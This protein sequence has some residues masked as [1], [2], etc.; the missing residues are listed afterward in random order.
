MA[1]P[2]PPARTGLAL[3]LLLVL[4]A[5][6]GLAFSLAKL[7]QIGGIPPLGYAIWQSGGAGLVLLVI[8]RVRGVRLPLSGRHIRYYLIAALTG[9]AIPIVNMLVVVKQIPVGVIAV[10][11]TLS[12][13]LTYGLAMLVGGERFVARRFAGMLLGFAGALLILIPSSSLPSP[14]MAP[15]V[16][17]ALITPLFFAGSN[18]YIAMARPEG[19]DS[20]ALAA[21]MQLAVVVFV[22]PLAAATGTAY[23]PAPDFT[24]ADWA[25]LA[26]IATACFTALAMFEIIRLAGV[27]FMSQVAYIVTLSGI[28][29]G[30]VFFDEQHSPWIWASLVVILAGVALV[31]KPA[32]PLAPVNRPGE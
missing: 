27:V 13:L 12:P 29:W 31:T 2:L 28:F 17:L 32:N 24:T 14:D 5:N 30:V 22:A 3:V 25:L 4:G 26:H 11:V 6:W 19:V 10:L 15:W 1:D 7:G 21:A 18:V 9:Q 23:V 16:A 8:G 20:L